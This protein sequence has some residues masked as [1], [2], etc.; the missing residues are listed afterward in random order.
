MEPSSRSPHDRLFATVFSRPA[1]AR[2]LL[3]A[4]LPAA[5]LVGIDLRTIRLESGRMI[6]GDLGKRTAD[7][8][9]GVEPAPSIVRL[10][11]LFDP[12]G[13]GADELRR[14]MPAFEVPVFDVGR[15]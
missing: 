2:A 10:A 5:A 1:E 3:R 7:L 9:H 12:G 11:D 14:R 6:D 15:I 8:L 4:A 13:P